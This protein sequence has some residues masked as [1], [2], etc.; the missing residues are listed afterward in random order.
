VYG[1][2]VTPAFTWTALPARVVFAAGALDRVP[3]EVGRLETDRVLLVAGG[4]SNRDAIVRLQTA[5]GERCVGVVRVAVHHGP[6]VSA[7][8]ARQVT[9]NVSADV[10]VTLGGGSVI[11]L[12]KAIVQ[13]CDLPLIA[14][15]HDVLRIGD[16]SHLGSHK[17]RSQADLAGHEGAA[18]NRRL[19]PG[20]LPGDAAAA[21]RR[22]GDERARP[23]PRS[24]LVGGRESDSRVGSPSTGAIG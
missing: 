14:V 10:V 18:P 3:D 6:S 7:D 24:T 11:G 1:R 19:R 20:T 2:T 22:I 15:P 17:R 4:T 16:D 9:R 13:A 23:L 21:G 5:L 8:E 12:G